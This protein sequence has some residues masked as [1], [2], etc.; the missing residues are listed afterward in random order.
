ME[1]SSE[2]T[3]SMTPSSSHFVSASQQSTI[4][5]VSFHREH[6]EKAVTVVGENG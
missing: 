5:L 6:N 3:H 4:L 1:P 2:H